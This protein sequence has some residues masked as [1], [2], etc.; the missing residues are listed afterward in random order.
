MTDAPRLTDRIALQHHRRRAAADPALFLQ[1]TVADEVEERLQEVNRQFTAPAIVTGWPQVWQGRL[2]GAAVVGDDDTLAL[3]PGAHDLVIH[4]LALHW[5]DDP[6][7]QLVQCRHAL[8]P[9]GLLVATLFAGQT[10]H[11]LRACLAEAESRVTGGLS[12]RVAPM[13]EVRDLG[14][15][16]HRAGFALPVADVTHLPVSYE[17]PLHLM[18]DL[19]AMGEQNA[20]AGRL[21]RP[22]RRAVLLEAMGLYAERF[23][24]D[25][26]VDATFEIV[27]LTGWAPAESQPQPLRP[28]S[29]RTRLAD[30]LG[31]TERPLGPQDD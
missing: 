28:G 26:R 7:G 3:A 24:T 20:L 30:A 14:G 11:E 15:L 27:T 19:R 2:P 9:D 1:E 8:R 29:A 16:L 5:A 21:R 22:T 10:L 4:G 18:R 6:V 13:G 23:V 25:G 12:P 31:A 17:T